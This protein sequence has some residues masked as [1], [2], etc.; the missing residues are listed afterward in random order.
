MGPGTGTAAPTFPS[1]LAESKSPSPG[2]GDPVSPASV[3]L[4]TGRQCL[5]LPPP[6]T[7]MGL[8]A[9]AS[10]HRHCLGAGGSAKMKLGPAGEPGVGAGHTSPR[11]PAAPWTEAGV[12]G[13]THR[14]TQTPGPVTLSF[15]WL[16][17]HCLVCRLPRTTGQVCL[18]SRHP[19]EVFRPCKASRR[20]PQP[21]LGAL[22][23]HVPMAP[24]APDTR[25]CPCMFSLGTGTVA[26][27]ASVSWTV[28]TGPAERSA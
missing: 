12:A 5:S 15:G 26:V 3:L 7:V 16:R 22:N 25:S 1:L 18:Q 14:D 28:S 23:R 11:S 9:G 6:L 24:F 10:G 8:Q 17:P 27:R 21:F 13:H 19:R 4:S 2:K 20:S